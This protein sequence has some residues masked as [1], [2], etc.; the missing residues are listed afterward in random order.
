ME[1]IYDWITVAMFGGLIVL[2]LERSMNHSAPRDRIWQYLV[3]SV[4]FMTT[5]YFGNEDQHVV[6]IITLGA[7]VAFIFYILKPFERIS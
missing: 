7:T 5:N 6:A 3:A 4:G 2:F 1:T